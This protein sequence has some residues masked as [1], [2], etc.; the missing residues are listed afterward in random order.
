ML[1]YEIV[2]SPLGAQGQATTPEA[3]QSQDGTTPLAG[4]S[5]QAWFCSLGCVCAKPAADRCTHCLMLSSRLLRCRL[6]LVCPSPPRDWGK[7]KG[8]RL[9]RVRTLCLPRACAH[10]GRAESHAWALLHPLQ[11]VGSGLQFAR[12]LFWGPVGSDCI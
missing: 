10:L 6:G 12:Q 1:L 7:G 5:R 3:S 11:A 8:D 2:A 9:R 4:G